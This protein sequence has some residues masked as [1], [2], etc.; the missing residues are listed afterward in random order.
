MKFRLFSIF[1]HCF[2][3]LG[4]DYA[5]ERAYAT[6]WGT[7]AWGG[8]TSATLQEVINPILSNEACRDLTVFDI[9]DNELCG[10]DGKR[11]SGPCQVN[12]CLYNLNYSLVS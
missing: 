2:I 5:G 3:I 1:Q 7:T 9:W 6:G 10:N 8:S 11:E 12:P 4:F